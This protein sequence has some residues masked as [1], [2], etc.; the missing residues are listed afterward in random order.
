MS[1]T[2]EELCEVGPAVA[3]PFLVTAAERRETISYADLA[4]HLG[5]KVDKRFARSWRHMGH[6][7]GALMDRILEVSPKSPPLNSLVVNGTGI[8][9]KGADWY[10]QHY[11]NQPY[12]SLDLRE[13]RS[14]IHAVHEAVWNVRDWSGIGKKAFGQKYHAE[15]ATSGEEDGKLRRHGFG[16]PPESNE[17]V[18]LKEY[19]AA[20]PR[21]FGAPLGCRKGQLEK[22]LDTFDEIDVW[23]MY[24]GEELAIEVKSARSK[25][26]DR[27]RGLFQC[28]KYRALLEARSS[29]NRSQ[30]LVRARL[31]SEVP[32]SKSLQSMARKFGVEIQVIKPLGKGD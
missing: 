7:A 25:E 21:R 19:V 27:R 13:K 4:S 30:S 23:F 31:V 26:W 14:V 12:G 3:M 8:P 28:V 11:L 16:G 17:H 15:P 9:G 6:V 10:V 2:L 20:H 18:R 1:Y 22:L 24:P 29:L 32:L 5:R